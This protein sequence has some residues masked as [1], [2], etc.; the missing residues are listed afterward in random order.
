MSS[1]TSRHRICRTCMQ[2]HIVKSKQSTAM[3][4]ANTTEKV[5][6]KMTRTALADDGSSS[7]KPIPIFKDGKGQHR[8][9]EISMGSRSQQADRLSKQKSNNFLT[10]RDRST[11][12]HHRAQAPRP[13]HA[14]SHP[15]AQQV[16][17]RRSARDVLAE[18]VPDYLITKLR[19]IHPKKVT[20]QREGSHVRELS[21]GSRALVVVAISTGPNHGGQ[22]GSS[23]AGSGHRDRCHPRSWK[24]GR[25]LDRRDG[26]RARNSVIDAS[27][28]SNCD[29]KK[30]KRNRPRWMLR[31]TRTARAKAK[32]KRQTHRP[33]LC[34]VQLAEATNKSDGDHHLCARSA[35]RPIYLRLL[36][37]QRTSPR[38]WTQKTC[39]RR[40]GSRETSAQ[41]FC[42]LCRAI[43][44]PARLVVSPQPLSWSVGA[45]KLAN[46]AQPGSQAD[47]KP[48]K[49]R[50]G[51][52][53]SATRRFA[54]KPSTS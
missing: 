16:V 31:L 33:T 30:P 48:N 24:E 36:D 7:S 4:P 20:E 38:R 45:S 9:V 52:K 40:M 41:L 17:Q 21:L 8:G 37:R 2:L 11:E 26:F 53:K 13:L 44:I 54:S 27:E 29:T 19:S 34:G 6:Q 14:G 10:L 49:L 1:Q 25:R 51:A 28:G 42:A 35:I 18:S 22:L 43:G 5:E 39:G 15:R 47:K 50:A 46:T 12:S 3:A 32:A 23:P